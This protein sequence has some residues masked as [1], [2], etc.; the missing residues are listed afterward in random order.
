MKISAITIPQ[1]IEAIN[2]W[3]NDSGMHPLTC[4]FDSTHKP[5]IAEQIG[6]IEVILACPNCSYIQR[7]PAL[8]Y[9]FWA[10]QIP[11]GE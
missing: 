6:Q 1:K 3:Q 10:R 8:V 2:K 4:G 5:L 11:E 7:I 9:S